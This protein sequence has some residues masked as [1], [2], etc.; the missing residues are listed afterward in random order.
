MYL[1]VLASA[2]CVTPS[3][4][5][6]TT[7]GHKGVDAQLRF[8]DANDGQVV[9][10]FGPS[11]VSNVFGVPA[12][13]VERAVGSDG[14]PAIRVRFEGAPIRYPD[15]TVSYSGPQRIAVNGQSVVEVELAAESPRTSEWT[16]GLG[17]E[18]PRVS[19]KTYVY[20]KSPRAQVAFT[21]GGMSAFTLETTSDFVG[22]PQDTPVQASGLGFAPNAVI[23]ITAGGKK[24][25]DTTSDGGGS[26]DS[27]FNIGYPMPGP[28]TVVASDPQGHRGTTQMTVILPT[29][30]FR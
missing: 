24:L 25:W 23:T 21:F 18:C 11:P 30:P 4:T 19:S 1:A 3:A 14:Q 20:G 9:F 16:V 13:T 28:Y 6:T 8:V 7:G 5:C 22:V 10:T 29:N 26:F 15:R 17:G 2:G 27:G 12:F